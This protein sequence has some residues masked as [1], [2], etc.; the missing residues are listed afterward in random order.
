MLEIEGIKRAVNSP[1]INQPRKQN[2]RSMVLTMPVIGF[3][4]RPPT[5]SVEL[6]ACF[7]K[8]WLNEL[9]VLYSTARS[10]TVS[11][12]WCYNGVHGDST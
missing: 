8:D 9:T 10:C 2:E 7:Q 4:A 11:C 6:S 5:S 12:K 3:R 1:L